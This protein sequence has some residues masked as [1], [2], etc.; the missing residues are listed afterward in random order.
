[1]TFITRIG[2][3]NIIKDTFKTSKDRLNNEQ[4]SFGFTFSVFPLIWRKK[5]K[6]I[7]CGDLL[8]VT[9]PVP[10]QHYLQKRSKQEACQDKSVY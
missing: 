4:Y 1:M 9:Q 8:Y 6:D 5:R 2:L 7:S 10:N 3:E